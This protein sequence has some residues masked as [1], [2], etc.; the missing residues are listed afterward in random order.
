MKVQADATKAN[1]F[2]GSRM[3]I[4]YDQAVGDVLVGY[5]NRMASV[6]FEVAGGVT[7]DATQLFEE[8][9]T[10]F[11]GDVTAWLN[12]IYGEQS[13]FGDVGAS[14]SKLHSTLSTIVRDAVDDFRNGMV[15]DT[16]LKKPSSVN[17]INT[18]SNSPGVAVQNVVG[19]S[20]KLSLEQH[21]S[22]VLGALDGLLESDE[23]KKLSEDDK[24]S[25]RDHVDVLRVELGKANAD[26]PKVRR[27]AG[28]ILR[29]AR[30]FGMHAAAAVFAKVALGAL[31]IAL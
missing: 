8:S 20:N 23:F 26:L 21:S 28:S 19:D 2:G 14:P 4:M 24:D 9:A 17:V 7:S 11:V 25:L 22:T 31:G 6:A 16:P 5:L 15:G 10:K 12:G 3:Y 27:W 29:L 1:A 18:I 13:A 30:E